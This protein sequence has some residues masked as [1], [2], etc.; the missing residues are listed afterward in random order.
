SQLLARLKGIEDSLCAASGRAASRDISTIEKIAI[1]TRGGERLA[2]RFRRFL[3]RLDVQLSVTN[4]LSFVQI[5]AGRAP[6]HLDR[7]RC[8]TLAGRARISCP[9]LRRGKRYG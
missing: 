4:G 6:A 3:H 2:I 9:R 8:Q 7:V 5:F 1:E